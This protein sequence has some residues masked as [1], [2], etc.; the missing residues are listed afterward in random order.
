MLDFKDIPSKI[1]LEEHMAYS[2]FCYIYIQS[3]GGLIVVENRPLH[4]N[5]GRFIVKV[6]TT[7]VKKLYIDEADIFPRYY[8]KLNNLLSE[9]DCWTQARKLKIISIE[10]KELKCGEQQ[11][12]D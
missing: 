12:T 5:R 8:F 6:F 1:I 4:C 3:D 9:I 2:I 7:D 10:A 11:R